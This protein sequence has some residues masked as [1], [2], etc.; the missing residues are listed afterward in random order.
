MNKNQI[1]AFLDNLYNI[2][3]LQDGMDPC[4]KRAGLISESFRDCFEKSFFSKFNGLLLSGADEVS[5][6]VGTCFLSD[7][8]VFLVQKLLQELPQGQSIFLI[9]HHLFDID[10]GIPGKWGAEGFR[11]ISEDSIRALANGRVSVYIIHLPLDNNTSMINTHKSFCNTLNLHIVG[12][13]MDLDI[14]P[15]GYVTQPKTNHQ[16]NILQQCK[17]K[18]NEVVCYGRTK[19]IDCS[20]TTRIG[21][22]AGMISSCSMLELIQEANCNVCVC[23][24]VII[25]DY[26]ERA[27]KI[28]DYLKSSDL[29]AICVSHKQSEE[30]AV[31]ELVGYIGSRFDLKTR[32]LYG[33]SKWK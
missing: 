30:L 27:L 14:C 25:R 20:S 15:L 8:T 32:F 17:D 4:S 21:V 29:L 3:K 24:D 28:L 23:G 1:V 10:A 7:E 33:S 22:V 16:V 6:V 18:F 9:A 19:Y 13:L 12:D 31:N 11:F 5:L 2:D 26:S